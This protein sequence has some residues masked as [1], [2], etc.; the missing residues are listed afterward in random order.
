MSARFLVSLIELILNGRT[1]GY[2]RR[3][4]STILPRGASARRKSLRNR[5]A[6]LQDCKCNKPT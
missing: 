3:F 2:F 1:H 5:V 4:G 6:G